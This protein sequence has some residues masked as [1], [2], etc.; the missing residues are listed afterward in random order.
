MMVSVDGEAPHALDAEAATR[1]DGR[2]FNTT[3]IAPGVHTVKA[4]RMKQDGKTL[5]PASEFTS[6][7]FVSPIDAASKATK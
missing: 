6:Q 2:V 1:V 5:V 3:H 4:W 7:Y